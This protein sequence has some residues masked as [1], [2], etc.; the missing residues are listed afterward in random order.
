MTDFVIN[1]IQGKQINSFQKLRFLLFLY[2]HP[3]LTGTSEQFARQLYLGD[4]AMI[5]AIIQELCMVG[6]L[7]RIDHK[8]MLHDD[9]SVKSTLQYLSRVYDDPLA[10]QQILD[11]V[12]SASFTAAYA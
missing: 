8:Y 10:R 3:E 12:R 1:F 11:Q 2:Q 9:P 4:M 7:D 6:L 5:E